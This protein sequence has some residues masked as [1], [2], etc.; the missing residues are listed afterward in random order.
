MGQ[1]K[2]YHPLNILFDF[3]TLIKSTF[4]I[5]MI[6]FVINIGSE[7]TWVK[8]GRIIFCAVIVL[9]I[10]SIFYKWFTQKY[11]AD[12]VS[13]Y[14]YKG[15]L[16]KSERTIPYSKIH[17]MQ[18]RQTFIHKLFGLTSVVFETSMSDADASIKF[19][20][21]SK[22][23]LDDLET[24]IHHSDSMEFEET[25][26]TD[27]AVKQEPANRTVHF[28][29]TR[30]DTVKASFTSLSFLVLIP[31]VFSVSSDIKDIFDVESKA[32][33]IL[34]SITATWWIFTLLIV[35]VV[36]LSVAIGVV[37]TFIKYG[38]YE[39]ASDDHTIFISKGMLNKSTFTIS[40]DKV[41]AIEITQS[42]IKRVLGLAEVK[43]I[44][45]GSVGEDEAETNSL[46]PFLPMG[47]AYAMVSEILPEYEVT[48]EM[49]HLPRKSLWVRLLKPS[50]L[51]IVATI[52][53][54]YFKPPVLD[55]E[56]AWWIISIGLFV[57]IYALRILDYVNTRYVLNEGFVQFKQ[58]S[59]QTTMFVSKRKKIIEV[60]ISR[61]RLQKRFGL[62][63]VNMVNR[64][65]PVRHTSIEDVPV[66]MGNDFHKWYVERSKEIEIE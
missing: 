36:I 25:D 50:W 13:F 14:L 65:K 57:I 63:S 15:L 6:L 20:V 23:E 17:N 26:E 45:A 18:R 7:A 30:K 27:P 43:L 28:R 2:R 38:R 55:I 10:V 49:H 53:L 64:A 31:I 47:R 21:I 37:R 5:V 8:Y 42:V 66:T 24:K 40:K 52:A 9:A 39:I 56:Q 1:L 35:G 22:K 60:E 33:E 12:N 16:N 3:W 19:E 61:T 41:Q 32:K 11:A 48:P 44:S 4:F 58:G 54:V 29:P 59:M 46:Y 62:S 51:W 34:M